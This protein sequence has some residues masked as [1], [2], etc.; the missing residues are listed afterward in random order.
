MLVIMSGS[1]GARGLLENVVTQ[2]CPAVGIQTRTPDFQP[3][4][5]ILTTFDKSALWVYDVDRDRRYP[6]PETA[7]CGTNCHLSRDAEWI[8]FFNDPTNTYN[9]MRLDGTQR[10]L[11][12]DSAGDVEWWD[13]TTL[14]VWTPGHDAYLRAEDGTERE[15]LPVSGVIS[16]QPGGRWGVMVEQDGDG[17]KRTLINLELRGLQNV[18]Q[19]EVDLGV[20]LPYFDSTSWSPDGQW[21]AYTAPGA[22]DDSAGT[23]GG[24]LF[25]IR[26]EDSAPTQWT[27]LTSVYGAARINGLSVGELSWSPDS[28]HIAF[29]VT[30]LIGPDPATNTGNATIH[31][32]D[33]ATGEL[34]VYCGFTTTEHTP[35]PPRL[36]WSPDGTTLAF[37][38][39][40]PG[41]EK[42]YLLLTLDTATGVFTALSEG[43]YPA[44]GT[45]DVVAWGLPAS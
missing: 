45:A 4:G 6:L 14:L 8:T 30:E 25:G 1:A 33:V 7:P 18:R 40:V 17:F 31:I 32:L 41:D 26:P 11:L 21:L 3:G 35:N 36:I 37:G 23:A 15:Y 13:D 27:D 9:K 20:D 42:G 39:N 43:I 10:S 38:G 28:A 29:W 44:L 5:I 16:I 22:F 24:E 19:Q 34:H 12:V 2:V